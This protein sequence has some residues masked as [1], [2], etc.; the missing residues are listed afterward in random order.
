M[1]LHGRA[2]APSRDGVEVADWEQS[3][4]PLRRGVEDCAGHRVLARRLGR[5]GEPQEDLLLPGAEA[6]DVRHDGLPL[7]ERPRLVQDDSV[8]A[9]RRL[10]G[11]GVAH[12]DAHPRGTARGDDERG[13]RGEPQG[14]RA[15]HDEDR[16][17]AEERG[18]ERRRGPQ[19]EPQD[20]GHRRHGDDGRDEDARHA[21]GETLDGRLRAL[22]PLDHLDDLREEG[23]PAHLLGAHDERA[24][25]V[26]RAGE[27]ARPRGLLDGDGLTRQ[28]GL[29]HGARALCEDAVHR[30]LFAGPHAEQ[31]AGE[32]RRERHVL[33]AS[34][35]AEAP[36]CLRRKVHERA[37]GI[38]CLG[39]GAGL[40]GAAQKDEGDDDARGLVVHGRVLAARREGLGPERA[41]HARAE[42]GEGAHRH[43]G[44]H[45]RGQV[46]EVHPCG[47]Q[48][49]A[50]R[51]ELYGQ[52]QGHEDPGETVE[53]REP[54]HHVAHGEGEDGRRE[55]EGHGEVAP[56]GGRLPGLP[57]GF[58]VTRRL[59]GHGGHAVPTRCHGARQ[60]LPRGRARHEPHEGGGRGEVGQSLQD[61]GDPG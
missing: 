39:L 27:D 56:E 11:L 29:V 21:V 47:L 8:H 5:G 33:L 40:E 35:R 60:V 1:P 53:V 23:L 24:G 6:Y 15:R 10:E 34:I 25:G 50:P 59:V 20:E 3:G 37:E 43:E 45:V 30:H 51:P 44:V 13:G 58:P 54:R 31:V 2:D 32:H 61:T 22:R 55:E 18:G 14:A 16:H 41:H 48:K 57:L 46:E 4:I 52:R 19:S 12:E 36:R 7:G 38:T 28:H 42:C 26:E 9:A 49:P 17:G